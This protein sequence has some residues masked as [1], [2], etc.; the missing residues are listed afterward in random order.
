MSA[1]T[2]LVSD[3]GMH[4]SI[5]T[6]L[7]NSGATLKEFYGAITQQVEL[8][9]VRSFELIFV[10][11]GSTD[12]SLEVATELASKDKKVTV[13]ELSRNFGHHRA[14]I[15]G[16][17]FANGDLIFLIDSDLDENPAWLS[18]FYEKMNISN[19]DVVFGIQE[20]RYGAFTDK[21]FGYFFYAS[22]RYLTGINQ[23]NNILTVRLM[24]K[25]YVNALLQ[26]QER[27]SNLGALWASTGFTQTAI[28]VEK[29][30]RSNS[31]YKFR[32]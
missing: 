25:I 19:A 11:D 12:D 21:I 7:Y 28:A 29:E 22:F 10:D 15:T 23:P 13:I 31:M 1:L 17:G 27:I 14:V 9:G 20:K 3:T 2:K 32:M 30:I 8:I 24:K 5:V 18:L 26:Y 16:L 6:T 4:L